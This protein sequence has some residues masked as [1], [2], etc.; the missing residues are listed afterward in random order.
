MEQKLFEKAVKRYNDLMNDMCL[1]FL[2][3]GTSL[4]E[5]R[6]DKAKW[7][8]RDLVSECQHQLD[9]Y[10]EDGHNNHELLYEGEEGR[11]MWKSETGKFR[12]FVEA[13]LPF[14]GGVKCHSHHCSKYDN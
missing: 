7:N 3:I 10:Y 6:E 2:T 12:R 1:E 11:R 8:I 5:D 13:Y 9:T 4:T 14:I